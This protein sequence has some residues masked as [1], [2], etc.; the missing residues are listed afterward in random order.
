MTAK[1]VAGAGGWIAGP[2]SVRSVEETV[3]LVSWTACSSPI[4][5]SSS[6]NSSNIDPYHHI[7]RHPTTESKTSYLPIL[8]RTLK[9]LLGQNLKGQQIPRFRTPRIPIRLPAHDEFARSITESQKLLHDIL[10]NIIAP[11]HHILQ[12]LHLVQ[13]TP[14]QCNSRIRVPN[15]DLRNM[16]VHIL[17]IAP[18]PQRVHFQAEI[19]NSAAVEVDQ[20]GRRAEIQQV[21][22]EVEEYRYATKLLHERRSI[23]VHRLRARLLADL[24]QDGDLVVRPRPVDVAGYGAVVIAMTAVRVT[25]SL[26]LDDLW[27]GQGVAPDLAA[28]LEGE[29]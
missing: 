13:H 24:H 19:R 21:G 28:D 23:M 16:F 27:T 26:D 25:V 12:R 6:S 4:I 20:I 29:F 17:H 22:L 1:E 3:P 18:I 11:Q 15:S 9:L 5:S 14:Q 7:S 8:Q 2:E 10:I